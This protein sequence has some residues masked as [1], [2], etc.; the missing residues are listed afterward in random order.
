MKRMAVAKNGRD[1]VL[2]YW[3][4]L[5]C[6]ALCWQYLSTAAARQH[7]VYQGIIGVAILAWRGYIWRCRILAKTL[8]FFIAASCQFVNGWRAAALFL[9]LA[10][11]EKCR[12]IS[13]L[14]LRLAEAVD[15]VGAL[16][17]EGYGRLFKHVKLKLCAR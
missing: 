2:V 10:L 15:G 13:R 1:I 12:E 17:L 9:H 4:L 11:R 3:R 16:S 5:A 7:R 8:N 14:L 6:A